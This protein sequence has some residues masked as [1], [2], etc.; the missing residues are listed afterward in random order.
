MKH[1]CSMKYMYILFFSMVLFSCGKK[2]EDFSFL[3][4][5]WKM[6][7]N[8]SSYLLEKWEKQSETIYSGM[9]FVINEKGS[10]LMEEMKIEQKENTYFFI[11]K[12]ENQN[13]NEEVAFELKSNKE[14]KYIF[15]NP[16]HDFPKK[17]WYQKID[18][19]NLKAGIEDEDGKKF[20]HFEFVKMQ[21]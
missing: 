11:A 10:N 1:L 19:N 14:G 17:V 12:V 9:A 5:N 8:D 20:Q 16:S 7:M 21:E 18:N 6:Q 4:G 15:E 3:I 2:K 13:N